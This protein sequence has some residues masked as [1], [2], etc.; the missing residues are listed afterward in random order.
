MSTAVEHRFGPYGGQYVPET[1]MPALAELE[2]AWVAARDDPGF[3][4]ELDGLLHNYVGR[5]SPLY[6]ASRLSEA[7]GHPVYLKRE[8]LNHTGAH[9]INNA[10]GQALLAKRMGKRRI[11]AETGAGQHGVASATACALLDLECVVYMGT[12]DMRRQKPNVERMGL[13]GARVEPVEAGA[14]TLKEAVS[15]AIRDW[16]A[17][18]ETTHYIIGS[19]VGPAPY[20]ALVRDLQRV[21]G[22]EARAQVL[23]D[24]GRLPERV[25]ACVGGG[26]NSIGIFIPFVADEAVELIGVEAAG[27]GLDSGRHGAPLTVGGR[28]GVLHGAYS[29]IMQDEDGQILEAHSISAGLDYPGSGPEHAWL[30]DQGR[31]RYVGITDE[32]ALQAFGRLARLE[33]IIPALES[34]HA[35]AWVLENPGSE[36]DVVCLSGRGDKDLA[37]ALAALELLVMAIGD[38][39]ERIAEAF[40]AARA[41][42]RRA[43]LMPY[44]MGGFPDLETSRAIALAYAD[45]GADLVELGVPF[46]DPLADG[47]VIHAADTAALRAGATLPA[48]LEVARVISGRVPVIVMCYANPILARGLER[49]LDELV[50]AEVSGLIVPDLPME[51]ATDTQAACHARG[52][53]FV[54]LVAPTTPADR[55][56]EICAS[57]SGFVYA[58]SVTGTT[59]ERT[60]D[61]E[62]L[63]GRDRP[64][65]RACGGSGGG[66]IRD[67]H[68]GAGGGGSGRRGRRGDRRH[69]PRTRRGRGAGPRRRRGGAGARILRSALRLLRW[70]GSLTRWA[71]SSPQPPASASGSSSG[72]S[73]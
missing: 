59:G 6:H 69:P 71:S 47:P 22:D 46:S 35:L 32:Q 27:E 52:L 18:V 12:E 5:P 54:P 8:D 23:Q 61:G 25:I 55:L 34:A 15:A 11:I 3:R 13:L 73:T 16:V 66:R 1:L 72:R 14:R 24:A 9:K 50:A 37:E 33:G 36:L 63:V 68:P 20:P 42:G 4:A 19:C 7:A 67:R 40:A 39:V 31:A 10:L 53:A 38:G 45:A 29:A 43:A 64:R 2:L 60:G 65:V 58:V 57:A 51:E 41:D 49:F 62:G 17:N 44:L 28:G 26:S 70:L 30:R 48:V 21:I 56:A